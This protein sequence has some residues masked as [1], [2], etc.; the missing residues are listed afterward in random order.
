MKAIFL[1]P[2][3]FFLLHSFNSKNIRSLVVFFGRFHLCI[4]NNISLPKSCVSLESKFINAISVHIMHAPLLFPPIFFWSLH[5]LYFQ[6]S[7]ASL[8]QSGLRTGT[9][10]R[11]AINDGGVRIVDGKLEIA[12]VNYAGKANRARAFADSYSKVSM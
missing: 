2:L 6:N 1:F 5:F 4:H 9:L 3:F 8:V 11:F 7:L 12:D 10:L